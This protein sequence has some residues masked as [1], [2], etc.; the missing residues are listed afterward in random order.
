[1]PPA[2]NNVIIADTYAE[3]A[4][5][6]LSPPRESVTVLVFNNSIWFQSSQIRAGDPAFTSSGIDWQ[7]EKF[8]PAGRYIFDRDDLL[9]GHVAFNGFRFRNGHAGLTAQVTAT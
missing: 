2:L 8:L 1:M 7:P 9:A 3:A 6:T 4:T 5:L